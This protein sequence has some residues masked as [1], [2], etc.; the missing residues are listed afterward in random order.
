[1]S[2]N[3]FFMLLSGNLTRDPDLRFTPSGS[4]VA[5]FYIAVNRNYQDK[6]TMEWV[7]NTDFYR[8]ITWYK[9]AENCAE[10][11]RKGDRVVVVGRKLTSSAY[12]KEGEQRVTLEVTANIVAPSLE[13]ASCEIK[14]NPKGDYS[15]EYQKTKPDSSDDDIDFTSEDIPF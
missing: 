6:K 7:E 5:T 13:F 2:L 9:L 8:I 10:S 14:K 4:A 3:P 15:G 1:M 12:E 11:L